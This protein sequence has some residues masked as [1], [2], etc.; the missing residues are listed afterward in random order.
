MSSVR[1]RSSHKTSYIKARIEVRNPIKMLQPYFLVKRVEF[2]ILWYSLLSSIVISKLGQNQ[3]MY[4]KI[5][6]VIREYAQHGTLG[7]NIIFPGRWQLN[8]ETAGKEFV[9]LQYTTMQYGTNFKTNVSQTFWM[10]AYFF[11]S[12]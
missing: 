8:G 9:F 2:L 10:L 3:A 6:L 7:K 5:E 1:G 4:L 12:L 11:T